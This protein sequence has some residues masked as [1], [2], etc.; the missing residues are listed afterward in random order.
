MMDDEIRKRF[1]ENERRLE[2]LETKL[3]GTAKSPVKEATSTKAESKAWYKP[4]GTVAKLVGLRSEKFFDEP[5]TLNDVATKFKAK[6]YHFKLSDLTLPIRQLVRH[7]LLRREKKGG[8]W[9][10]VTI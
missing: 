4:E 10:Y 7:G 1:E 5:K 3:Y 8:K 9:A 2:G 6:D